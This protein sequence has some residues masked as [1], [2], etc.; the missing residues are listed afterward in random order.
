[1]SADIDFSQYRRKEQ[2][3]EP[4]EEE[5]DLE[6]Y[7]RKGAIE[8]S[9][10]KAGRL[11]AQAGISLSEMAT[12]PVSGPI[13]GAQMIQRNP[14]L[15]VTERQKKNNPQLAKELENEQGGIGREFS[16]KLE[17]NLGEQR[18]YEKEHQFIPE[19]V[20]KQNWDVGGLLEK[21]FELGGVDIKPEDLSEHAVRW[22][23]MIKD[24]RKIGQLTKAGV[25][26]FTKPQKFQALAKTL[27]PT[28]KE[29]LRGLGGGAALEIAA[30]NELGP[31]G[32]MAAAV[33]GDI[34]GAVAPSIGKGVAKFAKAPIR[35]SK[36]LAA[37]AVVAGTRLSGAEKR[38]IQQQIIQD[39]RDAGI[40][41]DLGSITDSNL[42]KTIQAKLA[43][44]GLV[45]KAL[46]EFR[47]KLSQCS[48]RCYKNFRK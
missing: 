1:M 25:D 20:K 5:F 19:W 24:P 12:L 16:Q 6:Q 46:D 8:K 47:Q 38:A 45:G 37:R 43:S 22:A 42:V 10:R 34:G 18:E 30:E 31:I 13:I 35:T 17:K 15:E 21:G 11:G 44:S 27:L 36:E 32:A 23:A 29:A 9:T 28:G 3:A 4:E 33:I 2:E 39:F 41:A 14:L 26:L 7:R 40:Q 48:N